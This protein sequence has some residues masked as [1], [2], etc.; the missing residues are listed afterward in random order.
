MGEGLIEKL[1]QELG[2][3]PNR[4]GLT[5][6]PARV[7]KAW[8]FWCSGYD[9]DP[10]EVLKVFEDGGEGYNELV[11]QGG[12]P[13]YS[14]CVVGSTFVETP[15]GRVPIQYLEDGDW[16]YTVDPETLDLALVRC[17]NPRMTRAKAQ[18]VRVYSDNDTVVCTPD[19]RF[20]THNRGWVEAQHLLNGDS[21]VSL[22]R[23]T[24]KIG[25]G[26]YYPTV[27]AA[28]P[29]K[30]RWGND[31]I[32]IQGKEESILEHRF[33]LQMD[34]DGRK[35][36]DT[37]HH[38]DEQVW[39]NVP[40]NLE[41]LS[42]TEHNRIHR[43]LA[44]HNTPG[45][46][47]FEKR[48]EAAARSSG[49]PEVTAKR[50]ASVSAYWDRLKADPQAFEKKREAMREGIRT[51]GRNHRIIG[52]EKVPWRE[53]VWCMNIPGTETFFANGMAVHN[54]EHH[55]APFFGVA[56]IGYIPKGRIVGLSK[57]SRVADIFARRLQVQERLTTQIA[58]A[59]LE[60]LQP[61]AVGVVIRA[62]HMCMESRG[63]Q[64]SGTVTYTSALRGEFLEEP[65]TR[66]EFLH[67]VR[68]AD[69]DVKI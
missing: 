45:T 67:F 59:L 33:V 44:V 1:L 25:V 3:D 39:N 63:V 18:L 29:G 65:E 53:D 35:E 16:V 22:Y 28:H 20:L 68:R 2:E 27:L 46:P 10:A 19:H 34:R 57:L 17:V 30:R 15:R 14:H 51:S 7:M 38:I 66:A 49:R 61:R 43:R 60:H 40:E 55:M 24:A 36:R 31:R 47:E 23:S 58:D 42:V 5:E 50:S 64:R 54:C 69:G 37:V 52:V 21:V 11:F 13:I 62:R 9:Q 56:H 8:K 12:I 4:E 41:K 6:T 26:E 32:L 48:K